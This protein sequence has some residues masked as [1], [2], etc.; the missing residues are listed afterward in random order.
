MVC[1]C[2]C[3]NERLRSTWRESKVFPTGN[4]TWRV[5]RFFMETL[6]VSALRTGNLATHKLNFSL[7]RHKAVI[8]EHRDRD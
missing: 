8:S 1:Q 6:I 7:I 5:F 4:S 2:G 3:H